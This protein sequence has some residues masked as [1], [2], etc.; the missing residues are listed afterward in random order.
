MILFAGC[1]MS[2]NIQPPA[3]RTVNTP[4]VSMSE[5]DVAS[6][7]PQFDAYTR[8]I[9]GKSKVPGMAVAVIKNDSVIYLRSFG[10]KNITTME[11]IGPDTRFQLASISKTF[12]SASI[13]SMVGRGEL[14]WDDQVVTL[15]HGFQLSDQW[16]SDH[17]TIRDLLMHRTGLPAYAGDELQDIGYNR[18]EV[19]SKLR[20]V[21]LLGDYR[22]SYA[23]SNI[24]ITSA[25]EAAAKKVGMSWEDLVA[26]R[27]LV[28]A[29]MK[30][31]SARFTDFANAADRVDT[32]S[33]MNGTPVAGPLLND[34]V[35][36]PAG[37]VSSTINDM[38]RYAR[39]Q[40]NEGSIDG[41]QV[42]D[43]AALKETHR[44]QNIMRTT[45]T[46]IMAYDLGWESVAEKGRIR[47]EHGGDLTSGVSTYI[48]LY[49]EEKMA[50]VVLT[51][52]F[53]GGH[54]LKK[55]VISGWDDLYFTGAVQKDWYSEIETGVLAAMKPGASAAGPLEPLPPA[56]A[57]AQP[58]R[59][60][61]AYMGSY[62]QDYYGTLRVEP[63]SGGLRLYAGHLTEPYFLVPYDGDT[64]RETGTGTAVKFT[65]E[66]NGTVTGVHAV[67]LDHPWIK[68]D[69]V[70]VPPDY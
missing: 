49:P 7:I 40:L 68:A 18:Q 17:V 29:G 66:N 3:A 54:I 24:G 15:D 25:A 30:N 4:P 34:D 8:E 50:V 55:A 43:A 16:V 48:T 31:T 36:S 12:T 19:I 58:P 14:S 26:D 32:Y 51:N 62:S 2:P 56:P 46:S 1:A 27:V 69:F 22:S 37:G 41:K 39:L 10:V 59:P 65:T 45:N 61:A 64:F 5:K 67:M 47:V 44:P 60:P 52:G 70:R 28:P 63:D 42:I 57:G 35:N 13:A 53:P 33:M 20:L 6:L 21:P 9:F 38:A 23:Y 11:P